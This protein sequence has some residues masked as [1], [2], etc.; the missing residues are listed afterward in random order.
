LKEG[1]KKILAS[2]YDF[3][4]K[5]YFERCSRFLD[6]IEYADYYQRKIY[7]KE[8]IILFR[9]I[10][11]QPFT[12]YG[13]Q[14]LKFI[15][16]NMVKHPRIFA[17]AVSLG[18]SGHHFYTITQQSLKTE[19]IASILDE[20]YRYFCDLVNE[21]SEAMM[22]NSKK[23]IQYM[24]KLWEEKVK[25]LKQMRHT[26][27]NIHGDYRYELSQKYIEIS[28][29]MREKLVNFEIMVLGTAAPSRQ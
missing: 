2:I 9:S 25:I 12:P 13:F 17:E 6:N 3:N 14:Y 4:L 21:Y 16:R 24:T 19:K 27:N 29:K 8:I 15:F 23:H 22:D 10:F 20:K 26:I 18:I 5:N 28:K 1:Y 11:R 7:F